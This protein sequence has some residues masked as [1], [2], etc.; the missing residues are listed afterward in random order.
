M[1]SQFGAMKAAARRLGL[2]PAEYASRVL[3]GDKWCNRCKSWAARSMFG[4]DRSRGDG[5][6]AVCTHCRIQVP[7]GVP[8]RAE[9]AQRKAV[10]ESWCCGCAKWLPAET[11]RGGKCASHRSA[12]ERRRYASDELY[13]FGRKQKTAR[14][15]RGVEAVPPE[16]TEH[17]FGLYGGLCVYCGRAADTVDHLHAV[18]LGGRTTPG[19]IV[20][21]CRS[22]NSSKRCMPLDAWLD[23]LQTRGPLRNVL[24]DALAL[25]DSS[26]HG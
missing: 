16:G 10:G 7:D 15:V 21:A 5:L 13:R 18:A 4:A 17:L 14:R 25:M 3:L 19:N 9:R 26:L 23:K 1:G 22:C 11:V 24:E 8:G 12:A 20:P 6:D 2:A